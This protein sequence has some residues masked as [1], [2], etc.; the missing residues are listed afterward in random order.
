MH[1]AYPPRKSSNPPPFRPRSSKSPL[2]RRNRL[3]TIVGVL[4]GFVVLLYLL[5]RSG[6]PAPYQEYVPSGNPP[7][8]IVTVVDSTKFNNVYLGTIKQNRELYAARHGY[9]VMVVKAYDYDTKKSPQSWSKIMA[10][11][12]AMTKY[13]DAKYIWYLDQNA[14]IMDPS[15]SLE[16][17]FLEPRK[18]EGL[19]I[20]DYPVV[21]PDSIIKTSDHLTGEGAAMIISQDI[22]GLVTDSVIVRNG[23]FGKFLVEAWLGPLYRSYNFQKAER[24]T[25]EHIV[26][27]HPTI[28]S[29]LALIPQRTLA[30]Y[31]R[32]DMGDV[33][34]AGDFVVM[35]P[36]CQPTGDKSCEAESANYL[37]KWKA[38][39][40]AA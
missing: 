11:R 6:K 32:T 27:W 7:V 39:F 33:Y 12:H 31:T 37:Q 36:G 24:H 35:F 15:K 3:K 8:V 21:P 28:L 10:M 19:M 1:Y 18:L 14:Y 2:L 20:K 29:K 40:E 25:M 17:Q 38:T 4:A 9:Q 16:E 22:D 34:Q 30:S 13:P 5:T 26:Q 23:E